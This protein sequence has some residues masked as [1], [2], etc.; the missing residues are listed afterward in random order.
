M[1]SHLTA[2]E[3]TTK[4][5]AA[6]GDPI[7]RS[8]ALLSDHVAWLFFKWA[9]YKEMFESVDRI[10][11]MNTV[12]SPFFSQLQITLRADILLHI[13]R[14]ADQ[15]KVAG[16]HT[17]SLKGFQR[18][19]PPNPDKRFA[20]DL[21]AVIE[22]MDRKAAFAKLWR[23]T[24]LAH[25]ALPAFAGGEAVA[26]EPADKTNIEGAL[27]AIGE[28]MNCISR[29]FLKEETA[30]DSPIGISIGVPNMM[31][32]LRKGLIAQRA[33]DAERFAKITEGK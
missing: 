9:D 2:E 11:L 6:M 3:I 32:Y 4:Y 20:N 10:E 25:L 19:L 28:V 23:D 22:E 17:L 8:F 16:K 15:K 29:H 26:L 18:L 7:G 5:V 14:L 1:G 24:K 13:R 12:A 30:W 33:E 31:H 27:L 21:S